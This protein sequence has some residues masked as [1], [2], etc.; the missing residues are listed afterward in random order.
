MKIIVR[1]RRRSEPGE[2]KP[3]FRV[4]AVQDGDLKF[5]VKRV[6][7]CE[8]DE[9]AELTGAEIV[10]LTRDGKGEGKGREE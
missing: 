10:Y 9:I 1:E 3:R 8:L 6:R 2:K 5:Y 4:V 7:K